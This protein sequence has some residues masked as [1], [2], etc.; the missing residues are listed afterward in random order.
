MRR[1][2]LPAIFGLA[3]A[4]VLL[5][6]GFWQLQRLEW[7]QALLAEMT[8]RAAAAPTAVP[9]A[10]DPERDRFRPVRV[11]GRFTGAELHVLTSMRGA[12]P[13]FRHV[14][15]F[16]TS[17]GRRIMID[18]G[19]APASADVAPAQGEAEVIGNL[20]WPRESDFFTPEPD[21]EQGLFFAR[22]VTAMA[23]FL[24]T[25]PL[26]VVA[27]RAEPADPRLTPMPVDPSAIPNDHLGY[28]ITWFLLAAVWLGMTG[29]WLWRIRRREG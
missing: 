20:D 22:D 1:V 4:A 18:R 21:I 2:F 13:G 14:A 3:G 7:K 10:P 6:L 23:E 11:R 25:E 15:A 26:L 8:A 29:L 5:S 27:R 12:G 28:A 19:F 16:V 24:G 9:E 17:D